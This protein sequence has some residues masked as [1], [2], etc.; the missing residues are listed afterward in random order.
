MKTRILLPLFA[1]FIGV[2]GATAQSSFTVESFN[3][4][5]RSGEYT[6][7]IDVN[8]THS[9]TPKFGMFVFTLVDK[10]W[11]EAIPGFTYAPSKSIEFGLG[12]GV[13]TDPSP[14]RML[15]TVWTGDDRRSLFSAFELGGSGHWYLMVMNLKVKRQKNYE[16]GLGFRLQRFAGIGP[17]IE[18]ALPRL[19][20]TVWFSG[21]ML[22]PENS[23]ARNMILGFVLKP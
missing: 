17:R 7:Q 20:T 19:K 13:E 16:L 6:P 8:V 2:E 10:G 14:F 22:D 15:A 4:F 12:G 21:P 23:Y 18:V 3:K 5:S 1:L 9:I 11:A